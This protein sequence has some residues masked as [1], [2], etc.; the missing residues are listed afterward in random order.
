MLLN[1]TRINGGEGLIYFLWGWWFLCTKRDL[2]T[3]TGWILSM[4]MIARAVTTWNASFAFSRCFQCLLCWRLNGNSVAKVG[5][6]SIKNTD[7]L[8]IFHRCSSRLLYD[9]LLKLCFLLVSCCCG[10]AH[11]WSSLGWCLSTCTWAVL[12]R[13][14]WRPAVNQSGCKSAL[15]PRA[16]PPVLSWAIVLESNCA[17]TNVPHHLARHPHFLNLCRASSF[18]N[19]SSKLHLSNF[20]S[21]WWLLPAYQPL[22]WAVGNAW[23]VCSL[24]RQ[25]PEAPGWHLIAR[26]R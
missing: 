16:P 3:L 13:Q 21:A 15:L 22:Q 8:V 26:S 2:E 25:T 5:K 11:T 1:R 19:I 7:H 24:C 4:Q 20:P 12:S 10:V 9:H 6:Q 17:H 14:H 23:A 18:R